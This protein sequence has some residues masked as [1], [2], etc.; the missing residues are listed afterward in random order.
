[1]HNIGKHRARHL[2]LHDALAELI[3]DWL[4]QREVWEAGLEEFSLWKF[5]EWSLRQ[6]ANP[7]GQYN[8]EE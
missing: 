8:K 5:M 2:E 1:M 4:A 6:C 3:A 7:T